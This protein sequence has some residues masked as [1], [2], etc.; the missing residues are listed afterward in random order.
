[1]RI[2]LLMAILLRGLFPGLFPGLYLGLFVAPSASASMVTEVLPLGFRSSEEIIPILKAIVPKPGSVVGFHNQIVIKTT[3]ENLAEVRRV[4]A[5]L[6]TAPANLLISVRHGATDEVRRD[7]LAASGQLQSGNVALSAGG[8][9]SPEPGL[10]VSITG[11]SS[12]V[13][14]RNVTTR[15][16]TDASDMQSIRVLEGHEAFVH[17]GQSVPFAQR[18]IIATNNNVVVSD[19]IEYHDVTSGV[20]VRPRLNGERV[21]LEIQPHRDSL[22][23]SGGGQIDIQRS[24]TVISGQLGVWMELSGVDRSQR[25]TGSGIGTQTNRRV[26][27]QTQT[28][29]KVTRLP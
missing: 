10:G 2:Y 7:L 13:T 20:Y 14:V 21:T 17:T 15:S 16:R 5:S 1:M 23:A 24:A 19:T 29:V 6:D 22:S 26:T 9:T 11:G 18:S 12:S 8:S 25:T 28:F 27:N 4:L 3:P